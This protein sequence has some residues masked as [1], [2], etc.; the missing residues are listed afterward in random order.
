M[1]AGRF[2]RQPHVCM[3]RVVQRRQLPSVRLR[4]LY[5]L[6][7][8]ATGSATATSIP[9]APHAPPAPT[10]LPAP[11]ATATAAAAPPSAT[12]AA[13]HST[14]P[15]SLAT[16]AATIALTVPTAAHTSAAAAA[17]LATT[18]QR[19]HRHQ[20][21]CHASEHAHTAC[22]KCT[23]RAACSRNPGRRHR[24]DSSER[25]N[26]Q[27][28]RGPHQQPGRS[29]GG[30]RTTKLVAECPR[31]CRQC[32]ARHARRRDCVCSVAAGA[33]DRAAASVGKWTSTAEEAREG[34]GGDERS[35]RGRRVGWW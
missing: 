23:K 13:V 6:L 5:L 12:T 35:R 18:R 19:R 2:A 33:R 21:T 32:G 7:G 20:Y 29:R 17:A 22:C 24:S 3:P 15:A 10:A 14:C 30:A 8:G 1:H 25:L 34:A 9:S 31:L 28:K 16:A 27:S 11:I 26:C 4:G